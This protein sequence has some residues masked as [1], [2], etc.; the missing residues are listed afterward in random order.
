M[1]ESVEMAYIVALD[2]KPG[3]VLG[4]RG[5]DVLD[6]R[7]GVAEYPVFRSIQIRVFP[8]VLELLEAIEHWIEPE[9]HGAH[10]QRGDLWLEMGRRADSLLHQHSGRAASGN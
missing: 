10:V 4:A 2:L 9:I 7:E 6:I 8:L 3:A 5:E 1:R